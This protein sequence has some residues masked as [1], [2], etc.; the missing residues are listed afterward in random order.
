MKKNLI[1]LLTLVV[2]MIIAYWVLNRSKS[3]T[4]SDSEKDFA[5]HNIDQVNKIFLASKDKRTILLEK[6]EDIWVVNKT[7]RARRG[8][9]K[10]LLETIQQ[11]RVEYP[12]AETQRDQVIRSLAATGIKVEVY[13][14]TGL[15]KT[16]YVGDP[17]QA[18]R[19]TQMILEGAKTP[20]VVGIPGFEGYVRPRYFLDELEWRDRTVFSYQPEHIKHIE[21]NYPNRP[22]DNFQLQV[23][24]KDSFLLKDGR[25]NQV[26][27]SFLL[28]ERMKQYLS[29]YRRASA[30]AYNNEYS[31][32][33]SILNTQP[34]ASISVEDTTGYV[35]TVKFFRKAIDKRT[36]QQFDAEGNPMPYDLER[37][38]AS[39]N[40][41]KDFMLVQDQTF[42]KLLVYVGAFSAKPRI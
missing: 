24:N 21:V 31:K 17:A 12:I 20:F 13:D 23:I 22:E 6:Q 38:Y 37:Y 27:Y 3:A 40:N 32:K 19:G 28:K 26:E 1:Y 30:E 14:A 29:F 41:G 11:I 9:I 4:I 35:N 36:K 39:V 42:G 15:I 18:Y 16:Y 25:D 8:A 5:V 2:L 10:N 33:D 7:Y 34:F